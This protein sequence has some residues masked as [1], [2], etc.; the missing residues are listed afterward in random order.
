VAGG[1]AA[2]VAGERVTGALVAGSGSLLSVSAE[3]GHAVTAKNATRQPAAV[4][5]FV[6]LPD[7]RT[8]RG[9]QTS[10]EVVAH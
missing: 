4:N 7:E 1:G 10:V 5:R 3:L 8:A 2:V 6:D 9:Q